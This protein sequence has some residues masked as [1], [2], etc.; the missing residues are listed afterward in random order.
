MLANISKAWELVSP[1]DVS[2]LDDDD[3]KS[4]IDDDD[5]DDESIILVKEIWKK[6]IL[7]KK[8]ERRWYV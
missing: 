7:W 6:I 4:T 5:N 3:E 1:S 2:S 8:Y